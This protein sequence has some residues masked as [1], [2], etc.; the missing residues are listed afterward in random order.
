MRSLH[1]IFRIN[2]YLFHCNLS[3]AV[4][5]ILLCEIFVLM[6]ACV[7]VRRLASFLS[8]KCTPYILLF[9]LTNPHTLMMIMLGFIVL[10]CS[11]STNNEGLVFTSSKIDKT[12][13]IRANIIHVYTG[14]A[15]YVAFVFISFC[16]LMNSKLELSL[17]WG[18]G[19]YTIAQISLPSQYIPNFT[20]PYIIL[21]R[22][23]PLTSMA[24]AGLIFWLNGVLLGQL[25]KIFNA[26]TKSLT[27]TVVAIGIVMAS[28]FTLNSNGYAWYYFSPVNWISITLLATSSISPFPTMSYALIYLISVNILLSIGIMI[29]YNKQTAE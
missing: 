4:I 11:L 24:T 16:L 22:H 17:D 14:A 27:G 26:I 25:S 10:I 7:S 8:V 28:I 9:I 19:I 2:R 13:L 15:L 1:N 5:S 3:F 20:I 29:L 21:L 18:R 23:N 6:Q 12:H